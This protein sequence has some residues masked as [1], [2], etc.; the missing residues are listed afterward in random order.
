MASSGPEGATRNSG[1]NAAAKKQ[2]LP[3][4]AASDA[5]AYS[6]DAPERPTLHAASE[7]P[8][9]QPSWSPMHA[10]VAQPSP[11]TVQHPTDIQADESQGLE[12]AR[13]LPLVV[14]DSAEQSSQLPSGQASQLP[15][16]PAEAAAVRQGQPEATGS[17]H[18]QVQ[19]ASDFPSVQ[20]LA[21]LEHAAGASHPGENQ[22]QATPVLDAGHSHPASDAAT[23]HCHSL[24]VPPSEQHGVPHDYA[25]IQ[26]LAAIDW[27]KVTMIRF[28][29]RHKFCMP[30]WTGCSGSYLELTRSCAAAFCSPA[31]AERALQR[32]LQYSW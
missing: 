29:A 7:G 20:P 11:A 22:K 18:V 15:P 30:L 10:N 23:G 17:G 21:G 27:S 1:D 13:Q 28:L 12:A 5:A 4:A 2:R 26:A 3:E 31:E 24:D 25:A 9:Q 32:S 19:V 14:Q 8:L 16:S 6:P